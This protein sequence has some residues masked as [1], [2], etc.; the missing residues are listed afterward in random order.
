MKHIGQV[1]YWSTL[2]YYTINFAG[3]LFFIRDQCLAGFDNWIFYVYGAYALL[4]AVWEVVVVL[5]IQRRI[6]SKEILSFNRWHVVEL[7][8]GQLAR[9]DT[10]LDTCFFVLLVQCKIDYLAIP[11][12]IFIFLQLVY[13]LYQIFALIKVNKSLQHTQPYMERNCFLAFIRENMLLGTVLDSF[14]IDNS[15]VILQKPIAFG[16]LMG[17]YTFFCQDLP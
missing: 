4:T 15:V 5:L 11:V 7:F 6:R 17:A 14:C 3:P 16:K 9:F 10:F 13:P 2:V 8:M 12:G 1:L